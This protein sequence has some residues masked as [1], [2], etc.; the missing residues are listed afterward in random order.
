MFNIIMSLL[1][2][3]ELAK[4]KSELGNKIDYVHNTILQSDIDKQT[5]HESFKKMFKPVTTKLDDVVASNLKIPPMRRKTKKKERVPD[6]G[7]NIDDEVEDMN[8]GDLFDQ[9]VLPE[10]EKQLVPK[11]PTYKESLKDVLKGRKKRFMLILNICL[12][13]HKKCLQ[14]MMRMKYLI[15]R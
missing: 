5:S 12:K 3:K 13:N 2:W 8:L 4:K 1:K 10:Q 11:P 6:Y 15:M 14:N 9:P 7:I